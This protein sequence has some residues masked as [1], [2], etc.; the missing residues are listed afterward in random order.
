MEIEQQN[1]SVSAENT[2]VKT[3]AFLFLQLMYESDFEFKPSVNKKQLLELNNL[4]FIDK[5][6]ILFVSFS[7]VRK[8]YLATSIRITCGRNRLLT[9][10]KNSKTPI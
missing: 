2:C 7:E 6:N 4:G 10:T 3:V 9:I 8:T 1:N 5:K